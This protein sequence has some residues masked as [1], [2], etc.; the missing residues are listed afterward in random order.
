MK[1]IT[2]TFMLLLAFLVNNAQNAPA[3]AKYVNYYN[4][5]NYDVINVSTGVDTVGNIYTAASIYDS[6]AANNKEKIMLVKYDALGVQQWIKYYVNTSNTGNVCYVAK[7]LVDKAGNCYVC[8]YGSHNATSSLDFMVAKY[9]NTGF[10]Q[11]ISYYD[12]GQNIGDY[13]TCA[14]FD[15]A[16]NILVAGN[17]NFQGATQYDIAVVKFG[18]SGTQFWSYNYNNAVFNDNDNVYGLATDVNNNVYITGNTYVTNGRNMLT[19]KLNSNGVNQWT[20]IVPHTNSSSDEYGYGVTADALGNCYATGALS[21][22]TTIKYNAGGAVVWTNHNTVGGLNSF[23]P[24]HIL[25]DKFN[26]PIIAGDA[27]FSGS[28]GGSNLEVNKIN[29]NNGATIWSTSYDFGGTDTYASVQKDTADNVFVAGFFDG[30][31][32][33]DISALVLSPSGVVVWQTSFTNT[34]LTIGTDRACQL[35]LDKNKNII[36]A[37]SAERRGPG[38]SNAVDVVTLK[39]NTLAV[40][41]KVN[42]LDEAQLSIFPNPT[43][44][45]LNLSTPNAN[46]IGANILIADLVGKTVLEQ[47]LT[48]LNQAISLTGLA[49]GIYILKVS[50]T[51]STISKKLIIE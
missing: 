47:K 5:Q 14:K 18:I 6:T 17:A 33:K 19:I 34:T 28:A 8:G 40:G 25:L 30:P 16:G 49:K 32:N 9:D 29:G 39:Y 4:V 11:W 43:K 51:H 22:W 45:T 35:V 13:L 26:N 36:I 44:G 48:E 24:K 21:D 27:G 20:N 2:T 37:G 12:A 3:W 31:L 50:N 46:L 23:T 42:T 38:S 7:L 10:Q 41:I 15:A 1:K